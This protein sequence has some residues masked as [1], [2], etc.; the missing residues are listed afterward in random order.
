[1]GGFFG[2]TPFPGV[3]S[4]IPPSSPVNHNTGREHAGVDIIVA[5]LVRDCTPERE[6]GRRKDVWPVGRTLKLIVGKTGNGIGH[7]CG[8]C[9]V[10]RPH[11]INAFPSCLSHKPAQPKHRQPTPSS[12]LHP[13]NSFPSWQPGQTCLFCFYELSKWFHPLQVVLSLK[14]T[15]LAV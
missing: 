12:G 3:E 10:S 11:F 8:R 5:C 14:E 2:P 6:W 9:G 1:M 15:Y 13:A 7:T 4:R